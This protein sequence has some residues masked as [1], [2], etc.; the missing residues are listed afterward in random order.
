MGKFGPGPSGTVDALKKRMEASKGAASFIK[1]IP[2][3][4]VMT[5]RFLQEPHD[6]Y[7]YYEG[8]LEERKR[9]FPVPEG[10]D[11]D[12]R[13]SF[14]YLT[15]VIDTDTDQVIPLKVPS[16]LANR[17][18]VRFERYG[19]LLDRDYD[20]LRTGKG[21]DTEYDVETNAQEDRKLDQYEL[22]D[23]EA[24]LVDAYDSVFGT[25]DGE[26]DEKETNPLKQ[27]ARRNVAVDDE[28]VDTEGQGATMSQEPEAEPT[29]DDDEFYTEAE[30][31]KM[32]IGE[33]R[34]LATDYGLT[35]VKKTTKKDLIEMILE[36]GE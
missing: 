27:R 35:F 34:A 1:S 6:W 15:N 26:E 13:K 11:W 24:T 22:I 32:N 18:V 14:R 23:L 21:L 36:E 28:D 16:S 33:I 12:G 3:D 29:N 9:Y 2:N 4:S 5:V 17:L 10:M 8:Y 20:L 7:G 25:N 31:N 19:T 30:L